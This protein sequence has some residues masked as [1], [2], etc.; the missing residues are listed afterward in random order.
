MQ[1]MIPTF[2]QVFVV[3]CT[4]YNRWLYSLTSNSESETRCWCAIT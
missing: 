1:R 4:W 3:S 2:P